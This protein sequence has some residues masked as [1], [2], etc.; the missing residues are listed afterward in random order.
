M[1][2]TEDTFIYLREY[3]LNL[4]FQTLFILFHTFAPD[5]S[6]TVG[7]RLHFGAVNILLFQT[8][9]SQVN[10]HEYNLSEQTVDATLQTLATEIIDGTEVGSGLARKPHV[11]D[12][13][14]KKTGYLT[15]RVHIVQVG[16]EQHFQ[17]HAGIIS[18]TTTTFISGQQRT[19]VKLINNPVD[20]PDRS[21]RRNIFIKTGRK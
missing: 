13:L 19:D 11:K 8:D 2:V 5:E 10:K 3:A 20:K 6:V 18:W 17:K 1:V 4:L 15:T 9:I 16:E 14:L 21:I 12:V 7:S